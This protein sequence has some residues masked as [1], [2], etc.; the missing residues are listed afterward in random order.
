MNVLVEA[1]WKNMAEGGS[2]TLFVP[3]G[4][5]RTPAVA[6]SL[7]ADEALDVRPVEL[8]MAP[9]GRFRAA[10]GGRFDLRFLSFELQVVFHDAGSGRSCVALGLAG[11]QDGRQVGPCFECSR[12]EG[13]LRLCREG[14]TWPARLGGD[15]A[16]RAQ[17][18]AAL[19]N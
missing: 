2:F 6:A 15:P 14:D 11:D 12:P 1:S 8:L 19:A 17:L 10:L 9:L 4:E 5:G 3:L 16:A 13:T 7:K 18:A